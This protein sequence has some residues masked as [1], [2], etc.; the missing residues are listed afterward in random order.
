VVKATLL[1]GKKALY[2]GRWEFGTAEANSNQEGPVLKTILPNWKSDG[3]ILFLEVVG[4]PEYSSEYT[5]LFS[6]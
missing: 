4:H 3:F 6:D 5:F 1:A 2:L